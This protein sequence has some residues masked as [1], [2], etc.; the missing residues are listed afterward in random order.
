MEYTRVNPFVYKN[1]IPAQDY[2]S[3]NYALGDWMGNNFDRLSYTIKYTPLPRLKCLACYQTS[4][5]GGAGTL[6]Q[7]YFQQPQPAFLFN[8]LNGQEEVLLKISYEWINNLTLMGFYNGLTTKYSQTG[9]T[10]KN[11]TLQIGFTYGL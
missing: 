10:V 7:Q 4:R 2:T 1:L 9:M 5:K 6:A 3:F 11:N 8:R